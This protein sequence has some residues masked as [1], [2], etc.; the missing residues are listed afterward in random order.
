MEPIFLKEDAILKAL[1]SGRPE[2]LIVPKEALGIEF[3][4]T[5]IPIFDSHGNIIGGIGLGIG[6]E[7]REKLINNANIVATSSNQTSSTIEALATSAEKLA[8]QQMSLQALA[9]EISTQ[10]N[11]TGKIID[12]IRGVAHTVKY[13]WA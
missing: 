7:N 4:S 13:D 6:L 5:A 2:R 9:Q 8:T 12:I 3:E 1:N 11:E 10:I